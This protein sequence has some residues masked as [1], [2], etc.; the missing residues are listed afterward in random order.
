LGEQA[1]DVFSGFIFR[2]G[3]FGLPIL[4]RPSHESLLLQVGELNEVIKS[5]GLRPSDS[6]HRSSFK[7]GGILRDMASETQMP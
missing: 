5:C 3:H 7:I 1:V 2:G 6:L 4:L